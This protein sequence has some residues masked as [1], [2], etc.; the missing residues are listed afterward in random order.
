ME[1]EYT[2]HF[3]RAY[4]KLS[5]S[6]QAKAERREKLFRADPFDRRLDTHKLH[7]TLK[8]FHSFSIDRSYRIVF[9]FSARNRVIFLDIGD[10][11]V[12]Q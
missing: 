7:G 3:K 8:E 11:D 6:I 12:Y 1:I 4:Q 5:F 2:P 10:H 9:R